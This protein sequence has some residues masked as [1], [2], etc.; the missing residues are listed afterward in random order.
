MSPEHPVV[1]ENKDVLKMDLTAKLKELPMAKPG[2]SEQ[3]NNT[4]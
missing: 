4:G 3:Q 1:P 2:Q